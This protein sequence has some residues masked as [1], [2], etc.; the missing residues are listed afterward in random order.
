VVVIFAVVVKPE[1]PCGVR[2]VFWGSRERAERI[3]GSRCIFGG[4]GGGCFGGVVW[5]EVGKV[6]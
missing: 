5:R 6:E 4:V 3:A 1:P 2:V